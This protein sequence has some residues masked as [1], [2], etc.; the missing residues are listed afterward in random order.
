LAGLVQDE[1]VVVGRLR[2]D[3]AAHDAWLGD[4]HLD[5][6]RKEFA[7]LTLLARNAGKVMTHGALLEHVWGDRDRVDTQPLRTHVALL[8][9]KLGGGPGHPRLISEAGVGYRLLATE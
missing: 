1:T 7:L 4:E 8:R 2:I 6:A 9:K 3:V 5:L